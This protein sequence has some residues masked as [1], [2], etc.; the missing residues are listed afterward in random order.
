MDIQILQYWSKGFSSKHP[1]HQYLHVWNGW[2]ISN[3]KHTL[4]TYIFF[5]K[6]VPETERISLNRATASGTDDSNEKD[7]AID[8]TVLQPGS[9]K[10]FKNLHNSSRL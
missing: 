9:T 7:I 6:V 4:L 2:I 10:Y 8:F 1:L 5:N 3:D